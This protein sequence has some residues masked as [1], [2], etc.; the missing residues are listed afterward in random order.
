MINTSGVCEEFIYFDIPFPI[1]G[2]DRINYGVA[3][4]YTLHA[5]NVKSQSPGLYEYWSKRHQLTEKFIATFSEWVVEPEDVYLLDAF[6]LDERVMKQLIRDR[7]A[8]I[9]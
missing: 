6:Y 4:A 5:C 2:F 9:I 3:C 7:E 8:G 1:M